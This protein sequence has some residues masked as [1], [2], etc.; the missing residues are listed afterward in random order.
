MRRIA[1]LA[2]C[3]CSPAAFSAWGVEGGDALV[4]LGTDLLGLGAGVVLAFFLGL[5][6]GVEVVGDDLV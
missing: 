6:G 1:W 5:F 3:S 2:R 4:G